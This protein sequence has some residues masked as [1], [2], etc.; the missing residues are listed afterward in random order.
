MRKFSV[1]KL[2]YNGGEL[3]ANELGGL[4]VVDV[5]DAEWVA[6]EGDPVYHA[7]YRSA[8]DA[9]RDVDSWAPWS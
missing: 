4:F 1:R 5:F 2:L 3:Y 6:G 7:A 8:D 9:M